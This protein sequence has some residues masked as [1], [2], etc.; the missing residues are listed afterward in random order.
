MVATCG[1]PRLIKIEIDLGRTRPRAV[2]KRNGFGRVQARILRDC[3][4]ESKVWPGVT[5]LAVPEESA[6]SLTIRSF[7]ALTKS[8]FDDASGTIWIERIPYRVCA[9]R[10]KNRW[11]I[12]RLECLIEL[13]LIDRAGATGINR[14]KE[15]R[16]LLVGRHGATRARNYSKA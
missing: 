1:P 2:T 9:L 13:G 7:I 15:A 12:L 5:G 11:R 14:I 4:L 6:R 8:C 10:F 3:R 16:H